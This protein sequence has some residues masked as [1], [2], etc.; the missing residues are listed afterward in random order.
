MTATPA[1]SV[2]EAAARRLL[3]L[4]AVESAPAGPLWT[5]DDA[6][7]ASRAATQAVGAD[8]GARTAWLVRRAELAMQR[9]VPRD[10]AFEIAL[11]QPLWRPF[12]PWAAAGLGLCAGLL[13][14]ALLA[15]AYFNLMSLP[16]FGLL[17][18]SLG[19]YGLLL[20]RTIGPADAAAG[21]LRRGVVQRLWSGLRRR[22]RAPALADFSARWIAASAPLTMAR[23]SGLLHVAGATLAGGLVLGMYLR[24]LVF[25]YRAGWATTLLDP[26]LV[27]GL[28]SLVFAPALGLL[29]SALPDVD[30]IAGLRVLPGQAAGAS[31]APWIH[32]MALTLVLVVVLPRLSLAAWAARRARELARDFPLPLT[33]PYFERLQPSSMPDAGALWLLPHGQA[34]SAATFE[35]LRTWMTQA[36]GDGVTLVAA[37]P[38]PYGD[39]AGAGIRP[40]PPG[41]PLVWLDLSATP[42]TEVHGELL[43]ALRGHPVLVLDE[44][45]F[46][47]R[48]GAGPRLEERRAAW[49]AFAQAQKVPWLGVDLASTDDRAAEALRAA[50]RES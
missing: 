23:A 34:L 39:E 29:G 41:R 8:A 11:S 13:S 17:A 6:R 21:F 3:L 40:A 26:G 12:W 35:R 46:V 45:G 20:V 15:G 25:D 38:V 36:L 48:F 32:L 22:A 49:A 43:R 24:A 16:F 5:G 18:W 44:T 33:G 10:K 7:W 28:F 2:D 30:G 31:A 4:Q 1:D 9:L 19:L 47:K 14:D 37:D 42:E 50:L 27:H